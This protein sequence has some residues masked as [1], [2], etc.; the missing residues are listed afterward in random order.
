M[1][2]NRYHKPV[3]FIALAAGPVLLGL[4]LAAC[5]DPTPTAAPP[6]ATSSSATTAAPTNTVAP[7]T[8]APTTIAPTT[9]APTTAAPTTVAPTTAAPTTTAAVT[10]Q[11]GTT[12]PTTGAATTTA[13]AATVTPPL[14]KDEQEVSFTAGK[15]TL[16]G[17]LLLP[18]GQSGKMPA[19]VLISGSGPT[20][21]NGN[22]RLIQGPINS[23]YNFA[24]VLAD[25]GVASLR[26]DKL[27]TGKTGLA[28]FANNLND[29]GFSTYVEEALA[30]YNFLK[31]RPEIDP[32]RLMIL[33]H[34]EGGLIAMVVA[35]QLKTNKEPKALVLA[36]PLS[37]PYLQTIREQIAAQYAQA[38]QLGQFT[39]EQADS[40]LA[41]LDQIIKT[42]QETG[43]SPT[44]NNPV[45]KQ[46]FVPVNDKFLYEVAKYDPAQLAAGL[47]NTMPVLVMCGQKDVQVPCA[48]V[49]NLMQGFQ[50]AGNSKAALYQLANVDH[51][52]K[53]V[54]GT[55]NPA[56]DYGNPALKFSQ[57]ATERL[58]AFVKANL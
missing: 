46:I 8:V 27:A 9:V 4:L 56:T 52:F 40:A 10:T 48:D 35:D 15:D 58:G 16:Y 57:E 50:K 30:A 34:S 24:R 12:A 1:K 29:L 55:A 22:T 37:K 43:K 39:K 31:N 14:A 51:V 44:I 19:A 38:V 47:P 6:P 53:E 33:G 45:F 11:A 5:G 2:T 23:H 41:E 42:L 36:A 25:Q 54:P 17:T 28:S 49:Q 21:R 18:Q 20:D 26:Y 7:T 3:R 32:Q 13:G